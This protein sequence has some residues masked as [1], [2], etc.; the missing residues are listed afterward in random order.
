MPIG[1]GARAATQPN[2]AQQLALLIG[3]H[4]TSAL[5]VAEQLVAACAG[6]SLEAQVREMTQ[7]VRNYD[8]TRAAPACAA[9][10][11]RARAADPDL[12]RGPAAR[13]PCRRSDRRP[14]VSHPNLAMDG[15]RILVV[16]DAPDA[17]RLIDGLLSPHYRLHVACNG[18]SA[19]RILAG[20]LPIDLILLD[21]VMPDLDGYEVCPAGA[22]CRD[23][24]CRWCSDRQP[25]PGLENG[26]AAGATD[27]VSKPVSAPVLFARVRTHLNLRAA[28]SA[29][30]RAE[31]TLEARVAERTQAL[32]QLASELA[33]RNSELDCARR[34]LPGLLLA[35]RSPRQRNRQ[36][37]A[38]H[39][40][41]RARAGAA[42]APPAAVRRTAR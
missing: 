4:D 39:P 38:A 11:C 37:P 28:V 12:P 41:L 30:R 2:P 20:P 27:F 3:D 10:A 17:I 29:L 13:T 36:P 7:A 8:F 15:A 19:L 40:A 42:A 23:A 34:D 33:R 14:A 24:R 5:A 6:A 35:R 9:R 25:R 21:V 26:F 32:S 31:R 16:D 1:P 18:E 22:R